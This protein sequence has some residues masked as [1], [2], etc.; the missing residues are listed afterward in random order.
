MASHN[1]DVFYSYFLP[2]YLNFL[3]PFRYITGENHDIPIFE[4]CKPAKLLSVIIECS[5]ITERKYYSKIYDTLSIAFLN[6]SIR[7]TMSAHFYTLSD[8]HFGCFG[9]IHTDIVHFYD[10]SLCFCSFHTSNDC[11]TAKGR[12]L[13]ERYS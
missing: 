6:I 8:S 12:L 1:L 13:F 4:D 11:M 10:I 3:I 2:Y 5:Q 7:D 9:R